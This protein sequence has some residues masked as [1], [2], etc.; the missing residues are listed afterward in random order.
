MISGRAIY[1]RWIGRIGHAHRHHRQEGRTGASLPAPRR[2][3]LEV[4]DSASRGT[5]FDPQTGD[6][7]FLDEFRLN[8]DRA[9]L[10][11]YF[12]FADALRRTL[13]HSVDPVEAGAQFGT[14]IRDRSRELV[15]AS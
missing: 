13:G 8:N 3:R 7:D 14:R 12:D 5:D 1:R 11:Q 15:H 6:A 10:R 9:P 2:S 4:F